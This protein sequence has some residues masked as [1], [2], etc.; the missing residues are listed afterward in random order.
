MSTKTNA[1]PETV[2]SATQRYVVELSPV[3]GDSA[4]LPLSTTIAKW[5]QI[6]YIE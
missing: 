2:A 3:L 5:R 4:P 6:V 1:S